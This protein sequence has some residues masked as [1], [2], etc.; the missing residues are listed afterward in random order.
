MNTHNS[1]VRYISFVALLGLMFFVAGCGT[2]PDNDDS[3]K[4]F[5]SGNIAPGGSFSFTFEKEGTVEYFCDIHD[6]DMQ[7]QVT[8]AS[9]AEISGRDTV[10]MVNIQFVPSQ[11]TVAPNTEIVWINRDDFAHTVANG[12]PQ[13]RSG[14]Y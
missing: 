13:T 3:G 1:F 7:G 5:D 10:E 11:I 14:G 9:G 4:L 8:V 6:P 2:G 12:N